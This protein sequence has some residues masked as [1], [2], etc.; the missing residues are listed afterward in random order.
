MLKIQKYL[1]EHGIDKTAEDFN[2]IHKDYNDKFLLKY[3]M[4]ESDFSKQEVRESRGLILEKETYRV[5]SMNFIRFFNYGDPM[6]DKIDWNSSLI[7]EK[8]D[9]SLIQL[10]Y[11]NGKWCVSTSGMAEGEGEVNNKPGLTFKDLFWETTKLKNTNIKDDY[12]LHPDLIYIFELT[13]PYNIVVTPHTESNIR[14]LTVRNRNKY[15]NLKEYPYEHVCEIGKS[16]KVP[17]VKVF[18]FKN[19]NIQTLLNTFKDMPYSEEGYV[20]VDKFWSRIKI[21]NPKYLVVHRL[22]GRSCGH[23]ILDIIKLNEIDEF[24]STIPERK[25]ELLDLK[26]KYDILLIKLK[27]TWKNIDKPKNI[28]REERKKYA[29]RVF[30]ICNKNNLE[31]FTGLFFMLLDNKISSICEYLVNY[32]NKKLYDIL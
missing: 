21:K 2:L 24:I 18:D 13:T 12:H 4:I 25:E 19:K 5:L 28:T 20:V 10:Y 30:K 16:L 17:V 7:Q 22:K 32:D 23:N 3:N 1:K 29:E 15:I 27:E 8:L 26:E 11:H 9:G 6:C 31:S 14:L